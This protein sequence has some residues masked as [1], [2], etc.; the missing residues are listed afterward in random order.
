MTDF[1]AD[2]DMPQVPRMALNSILNG[3]YSKIK[4]K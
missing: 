2:K 3:L 4:K 1:I